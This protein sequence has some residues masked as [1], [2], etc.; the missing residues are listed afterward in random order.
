MSTIGTER[1]PT[2]SIARAPHMS[3]PSARHS[4]LQKK[5]GAKR[6]SHLKVQGNSRTSHRVLRESFAD[7]RALQQT[8]P[9]YRRRLC[10]RF[11]PPTSSVSAVTA[12]TKRTRA[13][14]AP[15]MQ[16]PRG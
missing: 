11:R 4:R 13:S 6:K 15:E 5:Y 8:T 3:P 14:C 7:R 12:E 1:E 2:Q 16:C 10:T 9:A